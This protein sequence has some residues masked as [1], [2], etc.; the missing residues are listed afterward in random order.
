[1]MPN[2]SLNALTILPIRGRVLLNFGKN[3]ACWTGR[4]L[5][6]W[7][8]VNW[9]SYLFP[10]WRN[11]PVKG[12][13][14]KPFWIDLRGTGFGHI[15][16]GFGIDEIESHIQKLPKE[17]VALDIG[18]NIGIWTRLLS[19]YLSNGMVYGFE[20]SPSTFKKLQKNCSVSENIQCICAALGNSSGKVKFKET[21]EPG[22]RHLIKGNSADG[23]FVETKTLAGWTTEARLDRVDFIKIDVEGWEADVLIPAVS[24]LSRFRPI[25]CFEFIPAFAKARSDYEGRQLFKL[26]DDL[27][28]E[29]FRL[30]KSGG[31]QK[32]FTAN[33]DWTNDYLARPMK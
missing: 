29:V 19:G 3:V 17:A 25:V 5:G 14:G 26:F 6:I 16:S 2:R 24:L 7:R 8:L 32:D 18:A 4:G 20:P 28:Y 23:I 10:S 1:M 30:D 15:V 27:N 11:C 12:P 22:L 31:V 13:D 21:C 9:G 33:Y